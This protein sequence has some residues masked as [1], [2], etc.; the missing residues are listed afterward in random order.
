MKITDN[1]RSAHGLF[2]AASLAIGAAACGGAV[3]S[4]VAVG[5][6]GHGLSEHARIVPQAAEVCGLQE[7]MNN[8]DKPIGESCA[9]QAK[10]DRLWRGAMTALAAYG[11]TLESIAS[12]S[13]A[14]GAGQ[15]E[16][17]RTGIRGNDWIEVEGANEQAAR[18]A[19]AA[20]MGKLDQNSGKGDL[21][22][23]VK[24]A[25]PHVKTICEGLSAYLE[26]QT[27]AFGDLGKD[28]EKKRAAKQDR[29]CGSVD[30][31][32]VCV[33]ESVVDRML[34]GKVFSQ[35]QLL[36]ADHAQARDAV[37]GFCAAHAKAEE[38]A[39]KGDLGSSRTYTEILEAVRGAKKGA[40]EAAPPPKKK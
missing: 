31:R 6:V 2:L 37:H 29:R 12:G 23:L 39:K 25:A 21:E 38:A 34:Y 30:S 14:E 35:A 24:E 18:D 15:I 16:A 32:T 36:E 7:A 27:K 20:L 19:T 1:F 22:R 26:T 4:G 33:S 10:N 11:E 17:A 3:Q 8:P 9:K 40:P 28:A 13:G 5:K